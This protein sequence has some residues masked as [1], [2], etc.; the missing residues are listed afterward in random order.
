MKILRKILMLLLELAA[1]FSRFQTY[2]LKY[3]GL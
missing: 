3:W 2:I 1:L